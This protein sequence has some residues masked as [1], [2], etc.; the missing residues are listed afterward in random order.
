MKL[1]LLIFVAVLFLWT[2]EL[3]IATL[4]GTTLPE[5]FTGRWWLMVCANTFLADRIA[6]AILKD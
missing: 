2:T 3:M 1:F 6:N 4:F 5:L